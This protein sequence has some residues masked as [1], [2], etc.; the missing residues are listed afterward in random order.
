VTGLPV[1]SSRV[2]GS[3]LVAGLDRVGGDPVGAVLLGVAFEH[4]DHVAGE[5]LGRGGLDLGGL[6]ANGRRHLV[7]HEWAE[8]RDSHWTG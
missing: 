7:L 3:R 6:F 8:R 1:A 4:G 2:N 5:L